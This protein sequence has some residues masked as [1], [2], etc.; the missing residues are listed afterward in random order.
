MQLVILLQ[1]VE[2]KFN[3]IR[4]EERDHKSVWFGVFADILQPIAVICCKYFSKEL[5][6]V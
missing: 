4:G 1:S 2:N 3:E 6:V 5:D